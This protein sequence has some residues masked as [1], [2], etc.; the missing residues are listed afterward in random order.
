MATTDPVDIVTGEVF[1]AQTDV[2]LPG[3]LPLVL[4]RTYVSSYRLGRAFGQGW[5]STLDMRLELDGTGA[6]LAMPD[7]VLLVY[8]E[9]PTETVAFP[10]T[11]PR[12]GLIAESGGY[13]VSS[14]AAGVTWHFQ[15]GR[16]ATDGSDPSLRGPHR[17][18]A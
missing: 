12:L 8:R 9:M 5:A 3:V 13:A 6:L 18:G 16:A 2:A 10:E 1:M 11:G 7:G 14:A 15:R 17:P 4:E